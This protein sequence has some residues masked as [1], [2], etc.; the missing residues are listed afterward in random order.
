MTIGKEFVLVHGATHG[1]WCWEDVAARLRA[2]GHRVIVPELPGH[3]R[4]AHEHARASVASYT[5][6]VR[7]AMA[8]EG[9][10]RGIVVGHSMGGIVIPKVAE[11]APERVA[12]LVFL[13]GVVLPDGGSLFEVHLSPPTRILMRAMARGAGNGTIPFAAAFAWSRWLND[14]PLGHPVVQAALPRLTPQPLWRFVER[15]DMKR[16][17]AMS[18]PRTYIRCL[19]DA[20]VPPDRAAEYARRLGV[21]PVDLDAAHDAML[22]A[23]DRVVRILESLSPSPCPLPQRGRG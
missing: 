2:R 14:L 5:A 4:R 20:A 1:A 3:G 13:A 17:Y 18:V 21:K 22:S 15:V 7:D 16:F 10:S 19:R 23:P 8:L 9:V 11:A 12:H 6:A